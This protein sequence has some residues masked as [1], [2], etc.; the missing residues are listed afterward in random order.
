[1]L[2]FWR[3]TDRDTTCDIDRTSETG[4]PVD[5]RSCS[6]MA[7]LIDS[8][9]VCVRMSQAMGERRRFRRLTRSGTWAC[10]MNIMGL[11]SLS[12]PPLR[13]SPTTPMI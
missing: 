12:R 1:M 11:G 9:S 7:L 8:G 5:W 6:W 10:G 4:S 13:M 3:D 2:N